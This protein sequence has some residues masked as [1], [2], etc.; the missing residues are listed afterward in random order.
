[1]GNFRIDP[2]N[3]FSKKLAR[4]TSIFWFF[5]MTWLSIILVLQPS[6]ALY[7]VYMGI[8]ATAVMIL[9]VWAYTKNSIYEKGA[10]ALLDKTRLELSL[11]TGKQPG[12]D[13]DDEEDVTEGES[14]G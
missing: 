1:M 4:R 6:A 7:S 8:I 11:K 5:F 9:N 10:F 3:Q 14:N 12:K 13:D 2:K